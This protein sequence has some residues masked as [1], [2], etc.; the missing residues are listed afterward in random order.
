MGSGP[1]ADEPTLFDP[2]E[3]GIP[4]ATKPRAQARPSAEVA[5]ELRLPWV[6]L[7]RRSG[8][9]IAHLPKRADQLPDKMVLPGNVRMA[10]CG[11]FGMV[12]PIEAGT[13]VPACRGC[14][15]HLL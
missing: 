15:T 5:I 12:V 7:R 1:V 4:A 2:A 6:V 8:S 10:E 11:V 3:Y 14:Y 9:P 13:Q